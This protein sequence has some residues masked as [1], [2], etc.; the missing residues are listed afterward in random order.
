MPPTGMTAS[1]VPEWGNP[2]QDIAIF[3]ECVGGFASTKEAIILASN[4]TR[5]ELAAN[6]QTSSVVLSRSQDRRSKK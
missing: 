6:K 3:I 4:K 2:P 5:Q 1:A